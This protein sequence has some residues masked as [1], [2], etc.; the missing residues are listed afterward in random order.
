MSSFATETLLTHIDIT[1]RYAIVGT[2][3]ELEVIN[4]ATG[5]TSKVVYNVVWL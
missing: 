4:S 3:Q 5:V 1:I 2:V